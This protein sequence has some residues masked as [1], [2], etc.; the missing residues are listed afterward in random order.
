M[1]N[2]EAAGRGGFLFEGGL[3]GVFDEVKV[4][5]LRRHEAAAGEGGAEAKDENDKGGAGEDAAGV[6]P[7]DQEVKEG[8]GG[9]D[10]LEDEVAFDHDLGGGASA[11]EG[12]EVFD[13]VGE[14]SGADD[15]G[16]KDHRAQ[17][18]RSV[19]QPDKFDRRGHRPRTVW[20]SALAPSRDVGKYDL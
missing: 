12:E 20:K 14:K 1:E 5:H 4:F 13:F 18:D 6:A 7:F 9:A 17:P 3:D 19:E 2:G 8:D 11:R 15:G 16:E 10:L